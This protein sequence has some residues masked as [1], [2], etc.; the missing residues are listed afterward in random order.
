MIANFAGS[1]FTFRCVI[2]RG[3]FM[4]LLLS[5][6]HWQW[7]G[8][9][10]C[11]SPH[12]LATASLAVCARGQGA[13]W[14]TSP[15][16][17][18][19]S[20]STLPTALPPLASA[21]CRGWGSRLAS[22]RMPLYRHHKRTPPPPLRSKYVLPQM[23]QS[24][25]SSFLYITGGVGEWGSRLLYCLHLPPFSFEGSLCSPCMHCPPLSGRFSR[26]RSPRLLCQQRKHT[27][28]CALP[29]PLLPFLASGA[30]P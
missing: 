24:P 20:A 7:R 10:A 15:L 13:A 2:G 21:S 25:T 1:H 26:A 16:V 29:P 18:L 14:F 22:P 4:S 8:L 9:L 11:A 17:P 27:P 19:P 23:K 12:C 3:D 5:R 6:D 30:E 28:A